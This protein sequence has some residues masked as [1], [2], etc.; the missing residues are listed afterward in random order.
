MTTNIWLR[1]WSRMFLSTAL[2]IGASRGAIG[3][4][5]QW[6]FGGD[7]SA[8]IGTGSLTYAD[9]TT[10]G[11]TAFGITN[12]T[13]VPHINGQPAAFMHFPAFPLLAQGYNA[14]FAATGPNGGGAYV[15]KYTMIFD[16]LSPG[17]LNWTSFF[18]T[19]P[20]NSSGNDGDFYLAYDGSLGI[21]ALGYSGVNVVVPDTWYRIAFAADLGAGTVTYYVNGVQVKQRTGSSLLE[22][23]FALYSNADAGHDLRLFNEGDTSGVYTHELYLNSFFFTDRTLSASEISAL[24]GPNA[25]GIVPEP[26]STALVL[27]AICGWLAAG[28]RNR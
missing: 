25:N 26:V 21:D 12:G 8:T 20:A 24:G 14:T 6:D 11:L 7:L 22:G 23:R 3:A 16:V 19:D 18:N 27:T 1:G 5:Y 10:G 15:N 13:T 28:R 17:P 2:L 9:G 4:D